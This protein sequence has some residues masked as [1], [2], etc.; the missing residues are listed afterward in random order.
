MFDVLLGSSCHG[1]HFTVIQSTQQHGTFTPD[2][3]SFRWVYVTF[4]LSF[5]ILMVERDKL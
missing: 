2:T 5:C 1:L 4:L 3:L